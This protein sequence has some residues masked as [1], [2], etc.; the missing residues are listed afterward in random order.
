M[1]ERIDALHATLIEAVEGGNLLTAQ[2]RLSEFV[3]M[4]PADSRLVGLSERVSALPQVIS[5]LEAAALAE[6]EG[7]YDRCRRQRR[8]CDAS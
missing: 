8:G 5:S 2:A 3:E 1:P 6:A 7:D 4:A